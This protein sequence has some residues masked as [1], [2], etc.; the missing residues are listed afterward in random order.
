[1]EIHFLFFQVI[2]GL[3]Q[4]GF[5]GTYL[6]EPLVR[7]YTTAAAA[8]AVVAQLKYILGVSPTRFSGPFSL[9]YVS[10]FVPFVAMYNKPHQFFFENPPD[11]VFCVYADTSRHVCAAAQYSSAHSARQYCVHHS[12][13]HCQ[14]AEQ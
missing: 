13:L 12:P 10:T 6:S 7:A 11:P 8:H 9:V 4:F 2:L 1:M 5:V 14:G 3:A